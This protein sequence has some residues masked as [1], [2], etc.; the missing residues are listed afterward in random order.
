MGMRRMEEIYWLWLMQKGVSRG[1]CKKLLDA[2]GGSAEGIYQ[3]SADE[4]ARQD[5][6]PDAD[7]AALREKSLEQTKEYLEMLSRNG[8]WMVHYGG[9]DYPKL[10]YDIAKPPLL[11]YCR[12]KRMDWN[13][14]LCVGVVGARKCT[15]YGKSAASHLAR[16]M[17]AEGAVIVSGLAA[18]VDAAAHTG[19]L[20]AGGDT[21]AVL[22]CGVNVVYPPSNAPLMRRI[23]QHGTILSEYPVGADPLAHHFPERNRI[24][25]GLSRGIVIVEGSIKSGSLITA[26]LAQEQGKDVFAVPGNI[27]NVLSRG[28]N[29][30]IRD[31]AYMVTCAEDILSQYRD[32]YI[33]I[34]PDNP[35]DLADTTDEG[36]A[37]SDLDARI[38]A[39]LTCDAV[40]IDQLSA[41]T[42]LGVP[43]LN[44]QLLL[45]EIAGK[46]ESH[47]GSC[48]SLPFSTN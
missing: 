45:L 27:N 33:G 40:H 21:I 37:V 19:A 6:L 35:P 48:Y 2:C 23:L 31:G 17:A 7:K 30:L 4:L 22:G 20:D 29:Y 34:S 25:S 18:G 5:Y 3:M 44:A 42:G 28:P 11:L 32:L 39:A 47:P 12:G 10:L 8:V 26:S 15:E 46:V 43:E 14:R 36:A 41:Q 24:I 9:E 16:D 38:L 13:N 1:R